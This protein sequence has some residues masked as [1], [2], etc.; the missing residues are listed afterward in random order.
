MDMTGHHHFSIV[1][2]LENPFSALARAIHRQ[3]GLR[4]PL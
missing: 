2:E 1:G 3:M 4:E